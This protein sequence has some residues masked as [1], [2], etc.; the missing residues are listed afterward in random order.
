[1][2]T[3]S[4]EDAQRLLNPNIGP[5]GIHE[6]RFDSNFPIDIV[7]IAFGAQSSVPPNRHS[8]LEFMYVVSGEL[9]IEIGGRVFIAPAGD[10]LVVSSGHLHCV[11]NRGT[12]DARI[13]ALYF[14]PEILRTSIDSG[15][16]MTEYLT[17]FLI[18][19]STLW[20]LVEANTGVPSRAFRII[21]DMEAELPSK[22][23]RS[24]LATRTYLRLL[25]LLLVN[26]FADFAG[27][28]EPL[29]DH[30]RRAERLR[31]LFTYLDV[32]FAEE[33]TIERASSVLHMSPSHFMSFFKRTTG[34]SFRTYLNRFRIAKAKS[35]L[36]WT[37]RPVADIAFETG[38]E[39]PS[40]FTLAFRKIIGTTPSEYRKSAAPATAAEASPDPAQRSDLKS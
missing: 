13:V 25:L 23:A 22:S 29:D 26:H 10:L 11:S 32:H 18:Q 17:P 36:L 39:S 14:E 31:P 27:L 12:D 15:E 20:P 8:Y 35:L 28:R 40:Y 30:V 5:Q 34:Q 7:H 19:D 33:I 1:M 16:E 24:R 4:W 6:W 2:A 3:D 9:T 37:D 21:Q 38:F